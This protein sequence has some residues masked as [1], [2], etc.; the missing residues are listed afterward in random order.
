ML[1]G[2]QAPASTNIE[3]WTHVTISTGLAATPSNGTVAC[4]QS[5]A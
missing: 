4:V 2:R 1:V 5:G 3:D